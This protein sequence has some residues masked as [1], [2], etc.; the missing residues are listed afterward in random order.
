LTLTGNLFYGNTA[1]S[2][3]PVVYRN[4]GTVTS[5]GYN[6]VDVAL[7]TGT[8]QSGFATATGDTTIEALLGNNT[9][10]PFANATTLSPKSEL[11]IIP[12]DF[13]DN[14]PATDFYGVAR[15]WMG[16]GGAVK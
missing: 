11:S 16:A 4:S 7:G 2:S 6:V 9:T 5:Y 8:T 10:T 12:A 1:N 3:G 14:M 13:A 15:T